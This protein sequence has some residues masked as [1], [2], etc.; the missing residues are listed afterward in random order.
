MCV[1]DYESDFEECSDSE[2]E[3]EEDD[4]E[5]DQEEEEEEEDAS[6]AEEEEEEENEVFEDTGQTTVEEE[7]KMDS[8]NYDLAGQERTRREIDELKRAM[9][10]ENSAV[11]IR[12]WVLYYRQIVISMNVAVKSKFPLFIYE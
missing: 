6:V 4:D 10:R 5:S 8:G 2:D 1:Q 3:I 12:R 7:K 11:M 9:E